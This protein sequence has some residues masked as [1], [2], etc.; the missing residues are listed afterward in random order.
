MNRTIRTLLG[1][2]ATAGILALGV[3]ALSTAAS[4][5]TTSTAGVTSTASASNFDNWGPYFSYNNKAKA[6]GTIS[7]DY[8]DD[9]SNSVEVQ[10]KLWDLDHRT[11]QQGGKCAYVE[12]TI[13]HFGDESD[14]DA[15]TESYKWCGAGDFLR[16]DFQS[17]DVESIDVQVSQIGKSGSH[18]Y[19]SGETFTYYTDPEA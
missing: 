3:P 8:N 19:K 4:A 10:G 1:A 16:F 7:V 2:T 6:K 13:H 17:D 18:L 15:D 14:D 12:F 5:S 11:Y 9:Q